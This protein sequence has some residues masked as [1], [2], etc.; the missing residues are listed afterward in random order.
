MIDFILKA[1][2]IIAAFIFCSLYLIVIISAGV[3]SGIKIFFKN[4]QIEARKGKKE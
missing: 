2:F 1:V 3:S 4:N